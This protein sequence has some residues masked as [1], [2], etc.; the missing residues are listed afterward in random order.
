MPSS[1]QAPRPRCHGWKAAGVDADLLARFP[2]ATGK[3]RQ[4]LIEVAGKRR[5]DGSLPVIMSSAEDT[6]PAVRRAALETVGLMG[7]P[8]QAAELVRLLQKSPGAAARGDL[9][10]AL[11]AICNR[12]GAPCL[13]H[14]VP[15][16]QSADSGLRRLALHAFSALGG[17][18]ALAAVKKAISDQDE[19]VQDEAV[20]TLSNWPNNWPEDAGVAEPLLAL[21][22]SGKKTSYQVQGLRGYLQYLQE[23]KKLTNADKLA[24]VN[25]LLPSINRPEV[26]AADDCRPQQLP[27][28]RSP[29]PAHHPRR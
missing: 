25:D 27:H 16:A 13:P 7:E 10:Q 29:G 2:Q 15:L 6:D 26:K 5:I 17:A 3:T 23:D 21:A 1:P 28:R 11:V 9:E 8:A 12:G 4:V 19:A 22:K 20:S 14:V 18:D 24:R